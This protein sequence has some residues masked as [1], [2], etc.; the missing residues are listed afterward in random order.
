MSELKHI[1]KTTGK[2]A[3]AAAAP[4]ILNRIKSVFGVDA[5]PFAL[6]RSVQETLQEDTPCSLNDV[7]KAYGSLLSLSSSTSIMGT[8]PCLSSVSMR[9]SS[10]WGGAMAVQPWRR[11]MPCSF[12]L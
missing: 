9:P 6:P 1:F 5:E 4:G 8:A 11:W 7:I 10:S 2:R 12:S 3:D